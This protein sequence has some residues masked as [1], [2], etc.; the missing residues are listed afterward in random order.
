MLSF[1]RLSAP[2]VALDARWRVRPRCPMRVSEG[3]R[4]TAF[5]GG[6]SCASG[7]SWSIKNEKKTIQF[8]TGKEIVKP[9]QSACSGAGRALAKGHSRN[10]GYGLHVLVEA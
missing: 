10:I 8:P 6:R 3:W 2:P 9:C 4:S 1:D 7:I 5:G